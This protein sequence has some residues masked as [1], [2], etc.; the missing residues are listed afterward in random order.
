MA[1]VPGWESPLPPPSPVAPD[2]EIAIWADGRVFRNIQEALDAGVDDEQLARAITGH[3]DSQ[4]DSESDA[5][6]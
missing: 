6:P 4:L 1:P 2:T 5:D 3:H